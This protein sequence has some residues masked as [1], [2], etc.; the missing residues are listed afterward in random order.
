MTQEG[1]Q[2]IT[3]NLLNRWQAE[4]DAARASA[5]LDQL[6]E[7]FVQ[8]W[9][10]EITRRALQRLGQRES[11]L[12]EQAADIR[13]EVALSLSAQLTVI[14]TRNLAPI[15]DLRA[16]LTSAVYNACFMRFRARAPRRTYLHNRLRYLLR[17]DARFAL[18]ESNGR[19]L[20]GLAR[21]RGE[22]QSAAL[23]RMTFAPPDGAAFLEKVFAD[24]G[25]PVVWA[26]LANL[27]AD[28]MGANDPPPEVLDHASEIAAPDR[29]LDEEL[30]GRARLGRIWGEVQTLPAAQRA[31]LLLNLRDP[32]GQ[33]VL[34]WIPVTGVATYAG[35]AACLGMSPDA[36]GEIWNELPLDDNAI[37][38]RLGVTRQQVINLRKSAR[39]RITRRLH[40]G[41][42]TDRN[43]AS[44]SAVHSLRAAGDAMRRLFRSGKEK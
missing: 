28:V 24:T 42:N 26:D 30:D 6:F 33:G 22:A 39:A 27:A 1:E 40:P 14:R 15:R 18:W 37:A 17:N 29:G 3:V 12:Q 36:L 41:G 5:L 44:H 9:L 10:V 23:P 43:P 2:L 38:T 13:A 34:E 4:E 7:V 32:R 8:P 21:W 16:Y 35:L 20:A 25:R 11:D 19:L 31:A